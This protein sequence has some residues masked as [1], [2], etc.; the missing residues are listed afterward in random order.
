MSWYGMVKAPCGNNIST[1]GKVLASAATDL[2]RQLTDRANAVNCTTSKENKER[3]TEE[4][5]N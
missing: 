4:S 2:G 3:G 1:W 5:E